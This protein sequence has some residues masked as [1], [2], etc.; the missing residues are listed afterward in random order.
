MK[1]KLIYFNFKTSLTS[2]SEAEKIFKVYH[3]ESSF[4]KN[5]KPKNLEIVLAPPFLFLSLAV[6][7]LKDKYIFG[8]QDV[9]WFNRRPVTGETSPTMLK[10]F[11]VKYS[12]VGHSE[13]RKHLKEDNEIINKKIRACLENEIV[14]VLC[15]GEE[16]KE[17]KEGINSFSRKKTLFNQ[18]NYALRGIQIKD[19]SNLIIA[20]EPIWAIGSGQA[21][22]VKEA[23][24]TI[25]LIRFWLCR[26]FSEKIANDFLIL[27][28]GS[29]SSSNIKE[30]LFNQGIDGVLIGSASS[31]KR[32]VEKI[33]EKI[34]KFDFNFFQKIENKH[35]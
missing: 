19:S 6:E 25:A 28:G 8:S 18:L 35:V 15:V 14:P 33:F 27:Y 9:F 30:F 20:Y 7:Q 12:L 22:N 3:Q 5:Q 26:R 17:G 29:V 24:K 13:R 32:E 4:F 31:K 34:T 11:G 23:E 16:K 1:K 10:S 21:E 2:S